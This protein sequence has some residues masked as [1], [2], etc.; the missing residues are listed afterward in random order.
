MPNTPSNHPFPAT[1]K[2]SA[3][4]NQSDWER[5][6]TEQLLVDSPAQPRAL[7]RVP[8]YQLPREHHLAGRDL[9]PKVGA[10]AAEGQVPPAGQGG[11][12][13]LPSQL[14][15]QLRVACNLN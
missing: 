13:Q 6:G 14:P 4:S 3:E 8:P 7:H 1:G 15:N 5:Q 9:R 2:S 11:Q 12:H 10:Q